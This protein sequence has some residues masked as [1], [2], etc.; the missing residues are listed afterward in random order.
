[1]THAPA[2]IKGLVTGYRQTPIARIGKGKHSK[3]LA[4]AI[5]RF[6]LLAGLSYWGP[7][8]A[9]PIIGKLS[10]HHEKSQEAPQ[11]ETDS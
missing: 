7:T 8:K 1:M 9:H 11:T 3:R 2:G 6:L 4:T 5:G 10:I